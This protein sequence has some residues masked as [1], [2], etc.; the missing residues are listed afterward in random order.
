MILYDYN[1]NDGYNLFVVQWKA[2]APLRVMGELSKHIKRVKFTKEGLVE[3]H[4]E[5]YNN[6][7]QEIRDT[8]SKEDILH[9][10]ILYLPDKL[11]EVNRHGEPQAYITWVPSGTQGTQVAAFR[12][13]TPDEFS[14]AFLCKSITKHFLNNEDK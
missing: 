9:S 14:M 5:S 1:A 4:F 2:P 12:K 6:L 7:P 3:I 13:D 8:V 11:I 10:L